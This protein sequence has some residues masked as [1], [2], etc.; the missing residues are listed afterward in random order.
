[1][2]ETAML[3]LIEYST[4]SRIFTAIVMGTLT[5]ISCIILSEPIG[6]LL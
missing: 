6:Y 2:L 4:G 1:M 5:I 3:A